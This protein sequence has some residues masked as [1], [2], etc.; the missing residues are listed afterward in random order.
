LAYPAPGIWTRLGLL[1][2]AEVH[3]GY[4]SRVFRATG[5]AGPLVV[6]LIE[7]RGD[8]AVVAA[9]RIEVVQRL[10]EM[11]P[12]VVGPVL[13]GSNLATEVDAWQ[14]VCY[15]Y[16]E[17]RTPNTDDRH[18]VEAMATTLATLH[19]SMST[20]VD[21][22]LPLVAALQ[23]AGHDPSCRG[24]MI[25]GDYAAANL[26]A[27]PAGLKII[28][29]DDC[30]HGS[31]EFEIGNSLYMKLFDSWHSGNFDSYHRFR[32]WFVDGYR[33]ASSTPLDDRL[34]DKAIQTRTSVLGQWLANPAKAPTGIRTSPPEWR[35][36]LRA[37]VNEVSGTR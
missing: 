17:G 6:K 23:D 30:G 28:D 35:Q 21:A 10:S 13:L 25:H 22:N 11:N 2:G 24:Q 14:A 9:H 27:T 16:V 15:P 33:T 5:E 29:F 20:L 36:R 34:V 31:V 1:P 19:A 12:A 4:Q 7:I 3:A 32:S 8:D 37:F 18:D 26:I